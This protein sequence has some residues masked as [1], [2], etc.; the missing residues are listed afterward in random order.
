M[1]PIDVKCKFPFI[2]TH[3]FFHHFVE[4]RKD[5]SFNFGCLNENEW[6]G[7]ELYE[8]AERTVSARLTLCDRFVN[9]RWALCEQRARVNALR[10]YGERTKI[11]KVERF[12]CVT[13]CIFNTD[14]SFYKVKGIKFDK[15]IFSDTCLRNIS[16][17]KH[18]NIKLCWEKI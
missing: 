6:R 10:A 8:N 7:T 2:F 9:A 16:Y 17:F 5:W 15:Y 11:G 3:A 13:I 12:E 4:T 1:F 14:P 18:R